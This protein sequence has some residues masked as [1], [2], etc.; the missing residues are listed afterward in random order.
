[1]DPDRRRPRKLQLYN[2]LGVAARHLQ[3][4]KAGEEEGVMQLGQTMVIAPSGEIVAQATTLQDELIVHTCDLDATRPY[5]EG[6]FHF[7]KNRRVEHYG[8]ITSQT[9]AEPPG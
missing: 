6:I 9:E 7:G 3:H 8:P 1:M 2:I 4:I 5:K